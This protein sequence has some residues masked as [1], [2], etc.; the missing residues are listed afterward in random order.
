L[1]AA[2]ANI[3]ANSNQT[4]NTIYIGFPG[5]PMRALPRLY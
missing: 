3:N 1:G 2:F 4:G 5:I